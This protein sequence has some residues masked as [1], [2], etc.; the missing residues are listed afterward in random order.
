MNV[1]RFPKV[2]YFPIT[3]L[4]DGVLLKT[5][6]QNRFLLL[7]NIIVNQKYQHDRIP[8]LAYTHVQIRKHLCCC[9]LIITNLHR[10]HGI[11]IL[12]IDHENDVHGFPLEMSKSVQPVQ[13]SIFSQ[14]QFIPKNSHHQ[15]LALS[16]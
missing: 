9:L 8:R 12:Y 2:L 7:E 11:F 1:G 13:S 14:S 10:P 5:R 15:I 3:Y 16:N 6:S 4:P